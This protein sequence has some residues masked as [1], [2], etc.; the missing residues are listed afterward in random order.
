MKETRIPPRVLQEQV[1]NTQVQAPVQV[2]Q[3]Q[4]PPM[5]DK[6]VQVLPLLRVSGKPA[7]VSAHYIQA[8][9]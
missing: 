1:R 3:V 6:Q 5:S 7:E 2:P 4:T 9:A 8:A